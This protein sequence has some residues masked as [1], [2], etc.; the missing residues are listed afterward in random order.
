MKSYPFGFPGLKRSELSRDEVAL[1]YYVKYVKL[2]GQEIPLADYLACEYH[3][4]YLQNN[5]PLRIV[6]KLLLDNLKL[7]DE[8]QKE[9]N[10]SVTGK[11][12]RHIG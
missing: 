9:K 4:G 10:T 7:R 2:E 11:R 8:W 5:D 12:I 1:S 6:C 3:R